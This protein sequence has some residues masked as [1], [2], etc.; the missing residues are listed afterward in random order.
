MWARLCLATL[1]LLAATGLLGCLPDELGEAR[2][3]AS[4]AAA[5]ERELQAAAKAEEA[6]REATKRAEAAAAASADEKAKQ[7]LEKKRA[8]EKAA[9]EAK[10]AAEKAAASA[11]A[12]AAAAIQNQR[13]PEHIHISGAT[14]PNKGVVNGYWDLAPPR[15]AWGMVSSDEARDFIKRGTD[16]A[17]WLFQGKFGRWWVGP[18]EL[19]DKREPNGW[20]RSQQMA[21]N[22]LPDLTGWEVFEGVDGV[23]NPQKLTVEFLMEKGQKAKNDEL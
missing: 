22:L 10:A 19:A 5:K 8:E 13:I 20:A 23:F 4:A 11:E 17:Y 7:E 6:A 12:A 3:K 2:S 9:Q 18:Q 21:K 1:L 14:G 15:K 16:N